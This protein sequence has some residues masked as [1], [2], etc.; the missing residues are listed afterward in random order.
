M[1]TS[2]AKPQCAASCVTYLSALWKNSCQEV[3][4]FTSY[5]KVLLPSFV[6]GM[7]TLATLA[8]KRK[9]TACLRLIWQRRGAWLTEFK[10]TAPRKEAICGTLLSILPEAR[11]GLC[12]LE[13]VREFTL[14]KQSLRA[15]LPAQI[16]VRDDHLELNNSAVYT[17][18]A[19]SW[20]DRNQEADWVIFK[21]SISAQK[22]YVRIWT[23]C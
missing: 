15:T 1:L 14:S 19:D 22:I 20:V 21:H 7:P 10:R 11:G 5:T 12:K 18:G 6:N 17:L 3:S 16:P 4:H 8:F 9:G 2:E 23:E 13:M